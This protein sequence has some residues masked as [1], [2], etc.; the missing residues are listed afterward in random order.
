[1]RRRWPPGREGRFQ[2]E[3]LCRTRARPGPPRPAGQRGRHVAKAAT[4]RATP[5][6]PP[7]RRR[8]GV[9]PG[10]RRGDAPPSD[11]RDATYF[12]AQFTFSISFSAP[13]A[14]RRARPRRGRAFGPRGDAGGAGR[15]AGL[16]RAKGRPLRLGWPRPGSA[17]PPP[18]AAQGPPEAQALRAALTDSTPVFGSAPARPRPSASR[19]CCAGGALPGPTTPTHYPTRATPGHAALRESE[20]DSGLALSSAEGWRLAKDF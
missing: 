11:K 6:R 8:L 13:W 20:N 15:L 16:R 5:R 18:R 10:L 7:R 17:A 2:N 14:P 19:P 9:T 1:M 3:S 12:A 4:P